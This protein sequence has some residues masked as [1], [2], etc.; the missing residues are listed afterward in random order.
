MCKSGNWNP[1]FFVCNLIFVT[2]CVKAKSSKDGNFNVPPEEVL[3]GR[4]SISEDRHQKK[5]FGRKQIRR[6]RIARKHIITEERPVEGIDSSTSFQ[7]LSQPQKDIRIM[8]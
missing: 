1:C 5:R 2:L 3:C 6:K 4:N 7:A 8:E